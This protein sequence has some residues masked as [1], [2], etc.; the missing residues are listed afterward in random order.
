MIILVVIYLKKK[1]LN[2]TNIHQNSD[3]IAPMRL[4]HENVDLSSF[5][6]IFL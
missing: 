2:D 1:K 5:K 3:V 4:G 6:I